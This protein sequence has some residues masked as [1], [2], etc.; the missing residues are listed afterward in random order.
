MLYLKCPTCKNILGNKEIPFCTE[1]DKI[2]E[3][4]N[5]T[6]NEKL[7]EIINLY[8]KLGI[9][10]YCCKMRIKTFTKIIDIVK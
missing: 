10:R 5:L 4:K 3:N 9:E 1:Y 8:S 2:S 6:D 7:K